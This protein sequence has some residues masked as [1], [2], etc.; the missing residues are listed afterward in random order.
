MMSRWH[1]KALTVW[2]TAALIA[3]IGLLLSLTVPMTPVTL[4]EKP[5]TPG[6]S[7][8]LPI[9]RQDTLPC[10]TASTEEYVTIPVLPPPTD[11]PAA[12]HADLNLA[13][14]GAAAVAAPLGL[15]DFGGEAD[16][17]A[18][19]LAGIF[20]D[21]RTATFSSAWQ[22]YDWNWSCGAATGCRSNLI[23]SP[24][25]TLLGLRTAPGERLS[26]P[27]RGAEIYDGRYKALVL[28]AEERRLTL[29]Y[30]R[31]DNVVYGYTVHIENLCVDFNLLAAYRQADSRGRSSLPAL[32]NGQAVG[33]AA[34]N[35]IRVAVRDVGSFM[36]PRSRKDWWQKP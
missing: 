6:F 14:R 35:E 33:T 8:Y 22:V 4:A 34:G 32:R 11:R 5:P 19:Q 28:Y 20:A 2:G 24:L 23:S 7:A 13:L 31:E 15:V 18:P 12:Q 1:K 10:P 29:K 21:N 16:L 9:I 25:V 30:T 3:A 26:I 36:D 27:G 17:D